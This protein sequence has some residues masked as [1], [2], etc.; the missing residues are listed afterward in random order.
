MLYKKSYNYVTLFYHGEEVNEIGKMCK[1][2]NFHIHKFQDDLLAW[3]E[4]NKRD[5]RGETRKIHIIF[6]FR[7]LCCNKQE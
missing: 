6:G 7:K 2:K 3:Y 4:K 5:F 1:L